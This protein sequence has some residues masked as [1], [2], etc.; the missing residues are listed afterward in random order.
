MLIWIVFFAL[1]AFSGLTYWLGRRKALASAGGSAAGLHSLPNY[2]GA[3][4]ALWVAVP[5]ALLLFLS[6]SFGGRFEH[7]LLVAK[8]PVAITG[9]SVEQRQL[10]YRDAE[11]MAEGK[12]ASEVLYEGPVK[13]ALAQ[14][15]QEA[16]S[17][18]DKIRMGTFALMGVL[19]LAGLL[20][21]Y[22][23]I[24]AK[25]WA[26]N[27]VESWVSNVLMICSIVAVVTTLGIIL[28][29]IWESARFFQ[30]VS[31]AE[32]L[33]GT[34]WSP[35]IGMRDD[36]VGSSGGFG[37]LP[38]FAGTFLVM[39]IAMLV[40][41]PVG[42]FSAIYL[43]E[44]AGPTA[45]A[46]CKPLLEVLAGVPTVVYGFFAALSVGPLFRE[47][48]NALGL[49]L[50]D[51][52][53]HDLGLYLSQVQNQMALVAGVVMGIML[54]PFV[55]SLSDDIINS[56]PQALRDGSY[57]MGATKSE[58]V[59]NV[60]LPAALPGI[61]GAFLLAISRAVGETMIVTMAAGLQAKLTLN[62]LETVTTV[63]VQIVT[64]LTG[65]Q[66]FDSPKTLS[67]FALGL[68]LFVVTLLLNIIALRI[69][70]KYREQYD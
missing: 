55:S 42:L 35:Q 2:Y 64:L 30:S 67:A 43:A 41:G 26:R 31:P 21:T 1:A 62:P 11:A 16:K 53:F 69:V 9:M 7:A 27:R 29:L 61:A 47:G 44:Y 8:A 50:M 4:V 60:V 15:A 10:F 65:D 28:S 13:A 3:Y 59:K 58:T 14:K 32:F 20:L 49:M 19:A 5:A 45:R 66:E 12:Q 48:F 37:A 68:T 24:N 52:Q 25:F 18:R 34:H 33:L 46:V 40:A 38:L 36:Q 22:P 23:R 57:A 51:G 70:Q 54:I 39:M 63:T 17:Y 56:V 6:V